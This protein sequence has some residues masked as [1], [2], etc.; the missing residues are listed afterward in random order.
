MRLS[1]ASNNRYA[2]SVAQIRRAFNRN[3]ETIPEYR[4]KKIL[5]SW[6]GPRNT[7]YFLRCSAAQ[8]QM[9]ITIEIGKEF[10]SS[11]KTPVAKHV[12]TGF[13]GYYNNNVI[14]NRDFFW[15]FC[16]SNVIVGHLVNGRMPRPD[17]L[18]I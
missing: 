13:R 8:K 9:E 5:S 17:Y 4:G 11:G 6:P 10:S 16:F 12:I 14:E 3:F 1:E 2:L 15:E 18:M 7:V